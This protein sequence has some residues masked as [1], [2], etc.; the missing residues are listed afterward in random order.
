M[1]VLYH[2]YAYAI[3]YI[4]DYHGIFEATINLGQI[5]VLLFF[6]ISGFI[7][8]YLIDKGE[9]RFLLKRF[10]RIYPSYFLAVIVVVFLTL[11]LF[12]SVSLPHLLQAISLLPFKVMQSP[13]AAYPLKVEWT[14]IYEVFFYLVCACLSLRQVRPFRYLFMGVWFLVIVVM[15]YHLGSYTTMRP[16][17]LQ[18]AFSSY[19]ILFILGFSLYLLYKKV[20]PVFSRNIHPIMFWLLIISVIFVEHLLFNIAMMAMYKFILIGLIDSCLMIFLLASDTRGSNSF[21]TRIGDNS[22]GIYLM[23]ASIIDISFAMLNNY[24]V[25]INLYSMLLVFSLSLLGGNLFGIIDMAVQKWIKNQ[26]ITNLVLQGK[27]G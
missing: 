3:R 17:Y 7:M 12:S 2:T 9:N 24:H 15:N 22:Y 8:S 10:L 1:V 25:S 14:L 18:I 16:S 5:G 11:F 27:A 21:I 6:V 13:D 23:H 4:P 26:S 20:R 19:D